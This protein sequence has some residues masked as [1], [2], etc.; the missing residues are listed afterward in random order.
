MFLY[1]ISK[2][3]RTHKFQIFQNFFSI[4][5][6]ELKEILRLGGPISITTLFEGMLFN[7]AIIIMGLI[8]V[9]EAAAYQ[10]TLNIASLAFMLPYGMS[11]AGAVR[12]GLA[13]GAR[14]IESAKR[15]ASTTV[16][17]CICAI[18]IIAIPVALF[19]EI[20]ASLFLDLK[21][22]VNSNVINLV[23]GFIPIATGF[24]L[25]DSIQV[26]ANQLLRGLKDVNWP[27][28]MTGISYWLFGFPIAYFLALKTDVGPNGVWYG[29]MAGLALASIL[30]SG[31][32]LS[33]LNKDNYFSI[34]SVK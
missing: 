33:K 5:F 29:L 26:A 19:P 3:K 30:L 13:A 12:I 28:L 21:K 18:M 20:T 32:L 34:G 8:G 4:K 25:F 2:D 17:A 31:R 1:Y 22:E 24:M 23:I 7:V 14:D 16:I 9:M 10:V 6:N 27:M 11:M 15:A